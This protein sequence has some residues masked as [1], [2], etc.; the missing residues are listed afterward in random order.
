MRLQRSVGEDVLALR[1]IQAHSQSPS[2]EDVAKKMETSRGKEPGRVVFV[3]FFLSNPRVLENG[4]EQKLAAQLLFPL[5]DF[6]RF[7]TGLCECSAS[8]AEGPCSDHTPWPTSPPKWL[9]VAFQSARQMFAFCRAHRPSSCNL[10]ISF[11]DKCLAGGHI[12]KLD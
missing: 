7:V 11:S 6:Y 8:A 10:D 12:Q 1:V 3:S 5:P 4:I 9:R 2:G